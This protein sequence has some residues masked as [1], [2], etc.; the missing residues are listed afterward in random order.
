LVNID[1]NFDPQ[2]TNPKRRASSAINS[3]Y[4]LHRRRAQPYQQLNLIAEAQ[5]QKL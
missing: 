4:N 1:Q 3:I 5:K 2:L